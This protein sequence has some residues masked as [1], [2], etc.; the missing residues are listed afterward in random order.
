MRV[1]VSY[2]QEFEALPWRVE[3]DHQ[4]IYCKNISMKV[5]GA[6]LITA[7]QGGEMVIDGDVSW[8]D[9]SSTVSIS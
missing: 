4:V 1:K 7:E 9:A 8:H 3:F 5:P 6:S 2:S